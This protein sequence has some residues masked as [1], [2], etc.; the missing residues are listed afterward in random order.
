M[1]HGHELPCSTCLRE[2]RIAVSAFPQPS[3]LITVGFDAHALHAGL[4]PETTRDAVMKQRGVI[5]LKLNHS[6]TIEADQMVVLGLVEDIGVVVGLVAAQIDLAQQSAFHQQGEGT[7]DGGPRNG[8][9]ELA[10]LF[11]QF[12]RFEV[13]I[14][15]KS[16][17]DNDIPLLGAAQS[18][19]SQ[20]CFQAL[21]D[22]FVHVEE[23]LAT[24]GDRARQRFF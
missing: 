20:V 7:I 5:V 22:T 16:S 18:L 9:V 10:R 19:A 6:I 4:E 3:K 23:R 1:I 15:G 11:Q 14:S 24:A 12:L 13:V 17:L 21:S 8:A 2:F